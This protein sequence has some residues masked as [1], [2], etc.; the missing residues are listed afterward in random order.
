MTLWIDWKRQANETDE[1]GIIPANRFIQLFVG[2]YQLDD[3]GISIHHFSDVGKH[4]ESVDHSGR[5]SSWI[6]VFSAVK[7]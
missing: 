5:S 1:R 4:H 3:M 6:S 2:F 7:N